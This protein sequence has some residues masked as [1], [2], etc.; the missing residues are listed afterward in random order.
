MLHILEDFHESRT[1]HENVTVSIDPS[2]ARSYNLR[3]SGILSVAADFLREIGK[4]ATEGGRSLQL[5]AL[6]EW[7][8]ENGSEG[9][10]W[11]A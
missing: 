11:C 10:L 9:T 4:I 7:D 1:S 3:C 6:I 2:G 5:E 8:A